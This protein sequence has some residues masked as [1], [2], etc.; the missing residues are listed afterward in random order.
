MQAS[1]AVCDTGAHRFGDLMAAHSP[2]H[3]FAQ[4]VESYLAENDCF[5]PLWTRSDLYDFDRSMH[6]YV[7]YLLRP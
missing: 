4:A 7:E 6:D 5:E 2:I 3:Y 1:F